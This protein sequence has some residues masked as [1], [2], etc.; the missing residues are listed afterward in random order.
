[1]ANNRDHSLDV[2]KG[3]LVVLMTWCHVLQ[4]FGDAS[5]FPLNQSL[6]TAANLLVFPG[7]VFAFGAAA[8][9]AWYK[10]PFMQSAPRVITAALKALGAFYLSGLAFRVVREGKPFTWATTRRILLMQDL[11]G[12]SE[13]LAAFFMLALVAMALYFPLNAVRR[14]PWALAVLGLA[15][16]AMCLIP[17]HQVSH[18][19]LRLLVGT[20]AYASFPVVQYLPYFLLGVWYARGGRRGWGLPVIA[21]T[22]TAAGVL[23][24]AAL[25][26]LPNRFPPDYGWVL[27]PAAG[28]A[29]LMVL[30][31]GLERLRFGKL[32]LLEPRRVLVNL[33]INSLYYLLAGNLVL[34]TLSGRGT[35][36]QL[37]F[38]APGLF[39]QPIASP[40]GS[41]WWTVVLLLS[42]AFVASLIRSA[43]R[44]APPA[45]GAVNTEKLS[46]R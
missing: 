43:N 19:L 26:V 5:L 38:R 29:A 6:E 22:M 12:W 28:L 41:F 14:R 7:F 37:R 2:F 17:Y 24:A 15:A 39:G 16:L 33:G 1:M 4:F 9:Y 3:L 45:G 35:P 27:L 46:G 18:P 31:M 36:P 32:S 30:A 25:G 20:T 11:P 13:F 10:K 42:A 40:W 8:E 21:L 34:F 23:R 44:K